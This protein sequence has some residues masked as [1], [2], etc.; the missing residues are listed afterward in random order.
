MEE[1]KPNYYAVIPASVRYDENLKPMEKLLY[2][3]ITALTYKTGECWASNNYFAR[4]YKATPQAISKWIQNL[5]KFGYVAI[6]YEYNGR[7]VKKRIIKVSTCVDRG[8]NIR[9]TGYQHTIKENNTSNNITSINNTTTNSIYDFL[10]ENGFVL[11]P[12]HYDVISKW[13]DNELTRHAIKQ[14]VLNNKYNINYVDKIIYSYQKNNVKTV[15]QAVEREEEF[16]QKR[17]TYYKKKYEIK[18]SRYEREQ[19]ILKEMLENDEDG[20]K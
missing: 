8:I 3:E 14:A 4:L 7:A 20:S 13:E 5:S 16:N 2:G 10:Q 6:D 18:E 9:L 17:D 12:I 19:R 1:E 11:A 15:Q